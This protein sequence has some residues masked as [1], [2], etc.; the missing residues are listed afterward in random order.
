MVPLHE[1][2]FHRLHRP[3]LLAP[4]ART[5]HPRPLSSPTRAYDLRN[6]VLADML[7]SQRHHSMCCTCARPEKWCHC[8]VGVPSVVIYVTVSPIA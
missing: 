6:T 5:G 2:R 3:P 8:A 1:K 4:A 7:S